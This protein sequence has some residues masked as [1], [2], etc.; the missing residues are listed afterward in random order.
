MRLHFGLGEHQEAD[1][2]EVHWPSGRI[3]RLPHVHADQAI[4]IR[5]GEGQI[6][7]PYRPLARKG[8]PSRPVHGKVPTSQE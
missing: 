6:P 4:V 1:W 5:E 3:D 2:V 8:S 7:S